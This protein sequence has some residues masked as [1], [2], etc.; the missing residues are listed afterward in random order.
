MSYGFIQM[1]PMMYQDDLLYGMEG[2]EETRRAARKMNIVMKE[3]ALTL[4][5]EKSVCL[6]VGSKE[7]R[8]EATREMESSPV[9]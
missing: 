2:M 6:V 8:R 7:Q 3:R 9:M 4:N 5:R 1:A